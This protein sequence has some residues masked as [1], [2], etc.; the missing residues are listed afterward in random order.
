MVKGTRGAIR[1]SRD[2]SEAMFGVYVGRNATYRLVVE[3]ASPTWAWLVWP[4]GDPS[5]G[6]AGYTDTAMRATRAART[7]VQRM[8][9]KAL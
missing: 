9:G 3:Q 8:D 1:W 4:V 2:S 5:S 7:A 6:Q